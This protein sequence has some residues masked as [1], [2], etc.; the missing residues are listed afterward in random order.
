[1]V[2]GSLHQLGAVVRGRREE[3]GASQADIAERAGVSR[4]TLSELETGRAAPRFANLMQ[5]LHALDLTLS[6]APAGAPTPA[7][8][9]PSSPV[10][11][12]TLLDRYRTVEGSSDG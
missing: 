1:M 4:K 7:P 6:I 11:L 9:A 5:V 3:L 2:V 10:S 12:D 8:A